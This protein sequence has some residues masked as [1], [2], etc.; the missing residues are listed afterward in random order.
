MSVNYNDVNCRLPLTGSEDP[1]YQGGF[2]EKEFRVIANGVE[3]TANF[4]A[5]WEEVREDEDEV[6][7]MEFDVEGV[8][9]WAEC[10]NSSQQ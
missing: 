8:T 9:H 10:P 1:Y 2:Y 6:F 3:T 4:W 7:L 5:C